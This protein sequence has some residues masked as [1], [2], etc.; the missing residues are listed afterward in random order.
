MISFFYYFA[1]KIH[2][3]LWTCDF[4]GAIHYYYYTIHGIHISMKKRETRVIFRNSEMTKVGSWPFLFSVPFEDSFDEVTIRFWI[5]GY[6]T[7]CFY[8]ALGYLVAIFLGK[9]WMA[10]RPAYDL[11]K[12]LVIWN[13]GLALFSF[14]GFTRMLPEFVH[15]SRK[16]LYNSICY[17]SIT[18]ENSSLPCLWSFFFGIYPRCP[19]WV[20]RPS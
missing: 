8:I 13:L 5:D 14:V 15:I 2:F 9:R 18:F 20:T 16:G 17:F 11:R 7:L 6:W 3:F 12:C 4:M 1:N 19:N 10:D